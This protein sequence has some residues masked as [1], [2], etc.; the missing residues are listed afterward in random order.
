MVIDRSCNGYDGSATGPKMVINKDCAQIKNDGTPMHPLF[1]K[2]LQESNINL[3]DMNNF[4]E[5]IIQ[6][7]NE[8]Y[9]LF[10]TEADIQHK[11]ENLIEEDSKKQ[12]KIEELEQQI[13]LLRKELQNAIPIENQ[14]C[15]CY[16]YT[17]K[18][19]MIVP[20]GHTQYCLSCLNKISKCSLCNQEIFQKI[21]IIT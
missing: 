20:C 12:K 21:K 9:M 5:M 2:I 15:I 14:C 17:D 13:I 1:I 18:K 10:L 11:L 16:G 6:L 3:F 8:Y 4:I 7:N 19:I